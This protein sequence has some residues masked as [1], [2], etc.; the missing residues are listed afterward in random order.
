MR[1]DSLD[2]QNTKMTQFLT[3]NAHTNEL[4]SANTLN[5]LENGSTWSKFYDETDQ[6]TSISKSIIR[7]YAKQ[8]QNK[9]WEYSVSRIVYMKP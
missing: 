6:N 5:L 4:L 3:E 7:V 1:I 9:T 2:Q 8:N